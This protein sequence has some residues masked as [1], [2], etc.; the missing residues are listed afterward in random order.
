MYLWI[1]TMGVV[2]IDQQYLDT[3]VS[4][5]VDQDGRAAALPWRYSANEGKEE[6]GDCVHCTVR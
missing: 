1:I 2:T 4:V 5:S 3:V 6:A